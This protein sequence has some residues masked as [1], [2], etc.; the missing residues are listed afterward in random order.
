MS[1]AVLILEDM[2][3]TCVDCP[4]HYKSETMPLGNFMFKN[5]YR[6][7]F[8]PEDISE[9]DGDIVYLND[10][11]L[12]G[13]PPWCPLKELPKR[14]EILSYFDSFGDMCTKRGYNMCLNELEGD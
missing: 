2:P 11:M 12:D 4:L 7:R 8:E 6:C 9:D 13:K 5:L 1:K 14:K 3:E 10:I